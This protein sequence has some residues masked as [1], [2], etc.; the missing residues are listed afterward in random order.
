MIVRENGRL[1]RMCVF[2][3]VCEDGCVE[4]RR[5]ERVS[6]TRVSVCVNVYVC[7]FGACES[8]RRRLCGGMMTGG[9]EDMRGG[10]G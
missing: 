3:I 7:V 10:G 5:G 9:S 1:M 4:A 6:R 8:E 2:V